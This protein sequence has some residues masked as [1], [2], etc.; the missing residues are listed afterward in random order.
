MSQPA[1]APH[2]FHYT[3]LIL[4]FGAIGG[5]VGVALGFLSTKNGLSVEDGATLVAAGMLPHTW[6]F[7]WAPV[8]D[9]T[10]SRRAWYL[11]SVVLCAVGVLALGAIPLGPSTLHL[12][13]AVVF[14]ANLASTTLGM[15]VEGMMAHLTPE[16]RRGQA[17]GWFQ[18]GNLGGAGVGGGA[19][20]WLMEH[21]AA[22]WMAGAILAAV[23]L[24]CAAPLAM[25]PDVPRDAREG[26]IGQAVGGVARELW[27]L[28]RARSGLFA[29]ILCFLPIS[30]GAASGVLA[31]AEVAAKWGAGAD[32]VGLVNGFLSGGIAA[33]GC[34]VGGEIC[35]RFDARKVY[36][37]VGALMAAVA[38]GMSLSPLTPESFVGWG[39]VYSFCTGLAYAA[40]TGFVLEVIGKAAAATKYNIFAAL[41]NTPITYMGLVLASAATGYGAVGMLQVEAGAGL[42][43][44]GL[45]GLAAAV[46]LRGPSAAVTVPEEA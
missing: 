4:P 39:L 41:S 31:Q 2:P 45:L 19:G 5:F 16:D 9:T 22:P 21:L 32:Q 20:L 34:L 25:L 30:T 10:L 11:L 13:Q 23:F 24:A 27:D 28:V 18:A 38:L 12:L 42:V 3:L 15:A 43:G 1:R 40:F 33:F 17:G 7:L 14:V 6:K 36:A 29:A 37:A 26:G 35:A 46:L 44:I 8:A